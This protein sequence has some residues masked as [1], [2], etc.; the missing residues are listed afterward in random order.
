MPELISDFAPMAD[1]RIGSVC[2]MP[3]NDNSVDIGYSL[4]T[5][6]YV[7]DS[8]RALEEGYRVLKPGGKFFWD[9]DKKDVSYFPDFDTVLDVTPGARQ[10]FEFVPSSQKNAGC[11]ICVKDPDVEF[12]GF[13]YE[14]VRE[15]TLSGGNVIWIKSFFRNAVYRSLWHPQMTNEKLTRRRPKPADEGFRQFL[16]R[17][18]SDAQAARF[19]LRF[20]NRD[21]ERFNQF[22]LKLNA[23]LDDSDIEGIKSEINRIVAG[24]MS[25]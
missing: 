17:V 5:L 16:E 4:A 19:P 7:T 6:I 22:P 10:V 15:L 25:S 8:L 2:E 11:I 20:R 23:L 13:N 12:N 14:V 9:I 3:V 1:L 24:M 21:C 18:T